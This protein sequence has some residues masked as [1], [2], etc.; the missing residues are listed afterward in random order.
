MEGLRRVRRADWDRAV[1]VLAAGQHGLVQRR[2]LLAL[3]LS[4]GA[5]EHRVRAGRLHPVHRGVYAL[6]HPNLS[7]EGRW[8]PGVLAAGPDAVLSH[9]SAADLWEVEPPPFRLVEVTTPTGRHPGRGI[10]AHESLLSPAD[11][12]RRRGIRV[13]VP[14]RTVVDLAAVAGKRH[15]WRA[16]RLFE[17]RKL[18]TVEGLEAAV[19]DRPRRRGNAS[20]RA[21]LLDAGFGRG[22][23]RSELEAAFTAFLRRYRLPPPERNVSMRLGALE[24]EADAVWPEA[25]LIVELDSHEFHGTASAFERDRARD[26]ALA[27]HGWRVIRITWRQLHR[28]NLQLARDLRVIL[29]RPLA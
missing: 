9:R 23:T 1:A 5:I 24:I 14:L 12:T 29:A 10:L 26:R 28:D 19:R 13:T 25:R 15:A 6:G 4:A 8:L 11:I 2:Q 27:A 3:G 18:V 20:L 16:F 17:T 21:I 7:R 22:I